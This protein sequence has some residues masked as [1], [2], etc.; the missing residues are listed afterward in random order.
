M[1][2]LPKK[3]NASEPSDHRPISLVHSL[4]K[5]FSKVLATRL[6]AVLPKIVGSNQGAFMKGHSVHENF[7]LVKETAKI[8]KKKNIPSCILKLD[9]AKAFDTV[10]WQFLLEVL[11]KKGFE[12]ACMDYNDFINNFIKYFTQWCS[13]TEN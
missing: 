1:I 5:N 9:I 2:L 7:K 8:L 10:A 6:S 13:R 12:M 3:T 11:Q 4:A